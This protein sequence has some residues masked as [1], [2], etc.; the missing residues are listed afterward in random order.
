M[1]VW[2]QELQRKEGGIQVQM[3]VGQWKQWEDEVV[4]F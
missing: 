3:G 4:P 1:Q 2:S